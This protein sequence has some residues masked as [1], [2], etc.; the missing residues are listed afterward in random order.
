M[1]YQ[2]VAF[3]ISE[4]QGILQHLGKPG[5]LEHSVSSTKDRPE[6]APEDVEEPYLT[7]GAH[8]DLVQR[9]WDELPEKLP[10][11]CR[12]VVYGTPALVHPDTGIVFG[13]GG[14]THTYA[15]RLPPSTHRDARNAGA[16]TVHDYPAYPE[17]GILASRLDL[18]DIGSDWV[19][20]GWH[21]GEESWC[22]AAYQYA[23]KA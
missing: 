17:L 15:L 14:G 10:Q 22:L 19:F 7:L 16:T 2:R 5:R 23:G 3:E 12:W 1:E 13:F 6:C 8:P 4:N 9:L 20:G 18:A 21:R 11:D